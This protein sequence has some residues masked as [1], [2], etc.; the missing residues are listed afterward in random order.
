MKQ[1]K[2]TKTSKDLMG[3]KKKHSFCF[4][5]G[6]GWE[7]VTEGKMRVFKIRL[8]IILTK[9][10]GSKTEKLGYFYSRGQVAWSNVFSPHF[11]QMT[12]CPESYCVKQPPKLQH[13]CIVMGWGGEGAGRGDSIA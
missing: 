3:T 2:S 12:A 10:D 13:C 5:K 7:S 6:L 1:E 8:S 4:F 9:N 11:K